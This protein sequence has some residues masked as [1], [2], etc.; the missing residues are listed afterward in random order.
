MLRWWVT[1]AHRSPISPVK[2][3]H[4]QDSF[5][6][7]GFFYLYNVFSSLG[8]PAMPQMLLVMLR[9]ARQWQ[10]QWTILRQLCGSRNL[11]FQCHGGSLFQQKSMQTKGTLGRKRAAVH[12]YRESEANVEGI[13][14]CLYLLDVRV[15]KYKYVVHYWGLF[16]FFRS[17]DKTKKISICKSSE[18]DILL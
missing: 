18:T 3:K 11:T 17:S 6:F 14:V 13:C 4:K 9:D 10:Q 5:W 8:S 12:V 16:V 15:S 1:N 7:I 2:T